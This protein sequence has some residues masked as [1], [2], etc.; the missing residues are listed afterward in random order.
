MS[1]LF[2][3]H[4]IEHTEAP[5]AFRRISLSLVE[6]AVLTGI[7]MRVFRVLMLTHGSN[8][9]LYLGSAIAV[10]AAILLGALTAHLSNYPLHQYFWRAPLFA[11]VEVASEMTVSALLIAFGHEAMGPV[12][13]HWDDW[14]GM[15][16]NALL[17][18]G[19]MIVFWGL[20]LAGLVQ[21]LRETVVHEE[22]EPEELAAHN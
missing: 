21:I 10:G 2:P 9:W 17:Y 18:R 19:I 7:V 14:P 15:A 20:M 22:E 12:R 8:N 11:V 6:M 13:A 3:R 5:K 16:L 4:A 1:N